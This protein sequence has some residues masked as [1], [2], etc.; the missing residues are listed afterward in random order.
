M[1]D[2]NTSYQMKLLDRSVDSVAWDVDLWL[3]MDKRPFFNEALSAS[4][5][6]SSRYFAPSPTAVVSSSGQP[7]PLGHVG[8]IYIGGA[9]VA[10]GYLDLPAETRRKFVTDAEGQQFYRTGDQGRLLPDGTL[11][12]LGCLEGDTQIKL[13]GLRIEPIGMGSGNN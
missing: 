1:R 2:F 5:C 11:L 12:F 9:G 10:I 4:I 8:E 6:L 3:S 7:Q 13:R